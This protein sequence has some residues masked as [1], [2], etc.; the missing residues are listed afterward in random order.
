MGGL[1]RGTEEWGVRSKEGERE[2]KWEVESRE[3]IG[4]RSGK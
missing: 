4:E 3:L 2:L 1:G